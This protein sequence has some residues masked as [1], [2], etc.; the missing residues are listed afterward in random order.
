MWVIAGLATFISAWLRFGRDGLGFVAAS[1]PPALWAF[2]Y[3]WAGLIGDYSRGLWIFAWY[4]TS[5]CGVIWCASRVPPES[6]SPDL[7]GRVVEGR[8]G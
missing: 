8:P 4:M 1:A 6:G 7:L 2:A 3:G 5:H